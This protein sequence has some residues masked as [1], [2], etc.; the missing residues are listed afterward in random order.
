MPSYLVEAFLLGLS[1]GPVCLAYCAPILV[2]L[3]VS[4]EE[5]HKYSRTLRLLGLF[6]LGRFGGYLSVGLVTGLLGSRIFKF[7]KGSPQVVLT[8][9]IGIILLVLGL[10]KNF[11]HL[12]LC[13]IWPGGRSSAGWG[14]VLGFL[15]GLSICPPFIAAMTASAALGSLQGSIFYFTAFF[16]GTALYLPLMI[17]LG[18]L[19]RIEAANHVAK[20]CLILTGSWFTLKGLMLL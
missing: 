2:P 5:Q 6:L 9:L 12:K 17:L 11:P 4:E 18:P 13:K 1:T 16:F 20:I 10:M 8:L 19:C 3:I 15:T 14:V 7:G